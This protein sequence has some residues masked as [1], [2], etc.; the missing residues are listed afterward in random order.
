LHAAH[1]VLGA[2]GVHA[3]LFVVRLQVV[4]EV[5]EILLLDFG[6]HVLLFEHDHFLQ[7]LRRGPLC[8]ASPHR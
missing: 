7:V 2:L 1:P 3:V 8:F 4:S 6:I 5:V